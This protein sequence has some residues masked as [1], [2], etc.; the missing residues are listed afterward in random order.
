MLKTSLKSGIPV[1]VSLAESL[2]PESG[3]PIITDGKKRVFRISCYAVAIAIAVSFIAKFLIILIDF[4][5]QLS[6]YGR[7]STAAVSPA[8]NTLG[9]WVILIPAAGG[10]LVGL[11]AY[12]GSGAI[13]G[14]GIPEAMEQIL[15]NQSKIKPAI[16]YLKP[17]SSAITIGT[18]G[19]FGAE[20]P[21]IA[22]GG[23]LGSTLG[24]ILHIT[25]NERKIL[26]S[27]GATAGM[28]AI[29]G[30]PVA[31]IFLA[32]ELLLFEFS[33]R[34]IIPVALACITGAAGHHLLFGA[35]PVFAIHINV[36]APGNMALLCY[37]L[38]GLF[39][40]ILSAGVTKAVYYIEDLFSKLPVHWMWWPA[41]GGLAVGVTGYFFPATLGVGYN[42]IINVLNNELTL[43]AVALLFV[44][45][46]IS[47]SIALGSG[48]SGGTL[49]PL[50][51][52]GGA[53]GLL[54][55]QWAATTFPSAG[56]SVSLAALVGMSAMFAGAS[57][58]LLTSIVFALETTGTS[59]ALPAL[60]AAC[61]A[62]YMV[63]FF[64][65]E[66]TI[67]T[68]KIARR[69]IKTPDSF[70]PDLLQELTVNDVAGE[71]GFVINQDVSVAE[72]RA[73][74]KEHPEDK[75][76]HFIITDGD[77]TFAGIISASNLFGMQHDAEMRI[78]ALIRRSPVAVH[79]SGT[80]RTA[81]ELMVRENVD[82]L[83]VI[84]DNGDIAG[85][86]SHQHIVDA[87]KTDLTQSRQQKRMISVRR[88]ALR[89]LVRGQQL[90]TTIKKQKD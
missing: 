88:R 67:M 37:S 36:D 46:F 61:T 81:L 24:Q 48:T 63:S 31:A 7:F 76:N 26:L 82:V 15:T 70:E 58:A 62:A 30:S 19:P 32:I 64:I 59:S 56:I 33:P 85:I 1:S 75:S 6:F 60:L 77:N 2:S 13:R 73:W 10:I 23:A 4:V 71:Q 86:L 17:L 29:F 69:G 14:H 39:I 3:Q 41:I 38:L 16:T 72:A 54:L 20:G 90:I 8:D 79:M 74:I 18:G 66:N 51:T 12:Y 43:Q 11:M 9:L 87:Y 84:S 57:R 78:G 47:W 25:H 42:N 44:F 55:G 45:K 28:S 65:M 80:L 21:I 5:T 53:A 34:S 50:L 52:I 68:E 89:M 49:A 40:G 22:T 83:P 27:C 35:S